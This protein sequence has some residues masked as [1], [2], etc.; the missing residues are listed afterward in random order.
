LMAV[1]SIFFVAMSWSITSDFPIVPA[2]I[3]VFALELLTSVGPVNFLTGPTVYYPRI[4]I[5]R[6]VLFVTTYIDI[7]QWLTVLVSHS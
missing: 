3:T 7:V 4:R 2:M 5:T 1:T 6:D